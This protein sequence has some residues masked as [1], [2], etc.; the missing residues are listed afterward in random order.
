MREYAFEGVE[1]LGVRVYVQK[2]K[3]IV[4]VYCRIEYNSDYFSDSYDNRGY[5]YGYCDEEEDKNDSDDEFLT[6]LTQKSDKA[7]TIN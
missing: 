1:D 7:Y 2:K 5:D 6:L 3:A 4:A